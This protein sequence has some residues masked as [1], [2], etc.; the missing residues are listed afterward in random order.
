MVTELCVLKLSL[1]DALFAKV[2]LRGPNHSLY[3]HS[4]D[5]LELWRILGDLW[6]VRLACMAIL[7]S[8]STCGVEAGGF[9]RR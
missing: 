6:R 4:L 3:G 5:L 1:H 8:V 9:N 2:S 7:P